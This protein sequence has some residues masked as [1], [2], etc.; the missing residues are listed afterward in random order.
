MKPNPLHSKW[1]RNSNTS[2]ST[3]QRP[4]VAFFA[5]HPGVL[6]LDLAAPVPDL[7]K[8]H[9]DRLQDVKWLE[10]GGH[11]GLVILRRDEAVGPL[12]NHRGDVAR[13]EKAIEA[14]IRAT[15]GWP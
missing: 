9:G 1:G 15:P 6:V 5:H 4:G 7:G 12:S 11:Q 2:A 3:A 14:Q 8:Q 13:S 10:P